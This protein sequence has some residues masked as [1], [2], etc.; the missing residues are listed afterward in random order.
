MNIHDE[1]RSLENRRVAEAYT[2]FRGNVSRAAQ[3]LGVSR[4]WIYKVMLR[5]GLH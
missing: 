5:I 1:I 3:A 4:K 2:Q